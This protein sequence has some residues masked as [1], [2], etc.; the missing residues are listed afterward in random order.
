MEHMDATGVEWG[1]RRRNPL[2]GTPYMVAVGNPILECPGD[3][4]QGH[5]HFWGACASV[6]VSICVWACVCAHVCSVPL[7]A[8]AHKQACL[9]VGSQQ[10]QS[11][12]GIASTRGQLHAHAV[13]H[14][15]HL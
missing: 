1:E 3:A 10:W 7:P 12:S 11:C 9:P 14:T 5:M 8:L 13:S 6:Y 4:P 2:A 15:R